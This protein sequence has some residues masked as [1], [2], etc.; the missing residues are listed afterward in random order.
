[1]NAETSKERALLCQCLA[2]VFMADGGLDGREIAAQISITKQITGVA[3]GADEIVAAT[4]EW[5]G[6]DFTESLQVIQSNFETS[7]KSQ[8]LKACIL[9]GRADDSMQDAEGE[10]IREIDAC[11]GFSSEELAEQLSIIR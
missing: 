4:I 11:L 3:R 7:F 2:A 1:M 9:L 6:K 8:I 5:G 10:R